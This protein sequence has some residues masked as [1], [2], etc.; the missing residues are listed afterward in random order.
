MDVYSETG[1]I[2]QEY[3]LSAGYLR[4]ETVTLHHEAVEGVK[5]VFHYETI[6]EYPNGGKD[7]K[8]VVD[9]P[10]VQAKDAY[11]EQVKR[12]I[13]TPYTPEELSERERR[14]KEAEAKA[15][16]ERTRLDDIEAALIELAAL[17]TGG[18]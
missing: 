11:D 4:E 15:E 3:D 13:Y 1:E 6:R 14:R 12:L 10:G 16:A 18:E 2:L 5:E 7:V 9:V 17:M 8:K